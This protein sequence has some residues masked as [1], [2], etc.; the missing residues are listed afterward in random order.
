MQTLLNLLVVDNL[1]MGQSSPLVTIFGFQSNPCQCGLIVLTKWISQFNA[2]VG[3][4]HFPL[5]ELIL[6]MMYPL[7]KLWNST[8]K[9]IVSDF[10]QIVNVELKEVM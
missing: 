6:A 9:P 2:K 3:I 10:K 1:C 5:T 4:I 8:F 7:P